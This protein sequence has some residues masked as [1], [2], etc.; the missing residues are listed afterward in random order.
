MKEHLSNKKV[1]LD[2]CFIGALLN[3]QHPHHSCTNRIYDILTDKSCSAQIMIPTIVLAEMS[4]LG[5]EKDAVSDFLSNGYFQIK[6]YT[7]KPAYDTKPVM[8]ILK[9]RGRSE[10]KRNRDSD[11]YGKKW[12]EF[13]DDIKIITIAKNIEAD[14]IL[15]FDK[16]FIE[17]SAE[18]NAGDYYKTKA[19]DISTNEGLAELNNGQSSLPF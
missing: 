17:S 9:T 6:A 19:V 15:T 16:F 1:V 8:E 3:R 2:T 11:E 12:D 7:S 14:Y 5:L 4:G 18:L 10:Y 13:T